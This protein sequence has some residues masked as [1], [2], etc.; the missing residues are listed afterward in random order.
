MLFSRKPTFTVLATEIDSDTAMLAAKASQ[1]A[2]LVFAENICGVTMASDY[3]K[4]YHH[5]NVD[6]RLVIKE[7]LTAKFPDYLYVKD[8]YTGRL[9]KDIPNNRAWCVIGVGLQHKQTLQIEPV[10]I[11]MLFMF[12]GDHATLNA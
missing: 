7:F 1:T 3:Y 5:Q 4:S 9:A 12:G 8:F 6:S 2:S 11:A 10:H